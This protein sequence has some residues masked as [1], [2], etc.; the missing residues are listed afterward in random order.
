MS[1]MPRRGFAVLVGVWLAVAGHDAAAEG[2]DDDLGDLSL[3]EL[4]AV[5]ITTASNLDEKLDDA[6]ASVIVL[7]RAELEERGYRQL[8]DIFDDIPGMDVVRPWGDNWVLV[9]WR[10]F[11]GD[12]SAPFLLMVDGLPVNSLYFLDVD[13]PLTALPLT[14]IDRV[15]VVQGPASSV[16]G[17]NAFMGVVNV[18]TVSDAERDGVTHEVRLGIGSDQSRLADATVLYKHG[19]WRLRVSARFE[20]GLLDDAHNDLYEFTRDA[21]YEGALGHD[22]WGGFIDNPSFAGFR[23]RHTARAAEAHLYH[24]D[25]ELAVRWMSFSSGYG[26]EYAGDRVLNNAV[27]TR[28]ELDAY[29]RHTAPL[30]RTL[31]SR[32]VLRY[33]QGGIPA[34]SFFVDGYRDPL[35]GRVAA[36]SYWHAQNASW[37]GYQDFALAPVGGWSLITGIK[38]EQKDLQKAYD[39]TGEG[40]AGTPGGYQPVATIDATTYPYPAPPTPVRQRQN[41]ILTEDVGAYIQVRRELSANHHLHLGGRIDRNSGYDL[42]PT[43]RAGYV[44]RISKPL[45]IKALYGE[46]FQEPPPRVLY[47]GWTG[48]G[49]D[50]DL[51]PQR[52]QTLE[53]D[54]TLTLPTLW[55]GV[56][57]YAVHSADTISV[58]AIPRNSG[59]QLVI[60][61]DYSFRG[62]VPVKGV[63]RLE[64]WGSYTRL[65]HAEE[66]LTATDGTRE[67]V[68][69][70]DLSRDK[71]HLGASLRYDRHLSAT[72]RGRWYGRRTTTPTN[73]IREVD[74]YAT[75]DATIGY[76]DVAG[77]GLGVSA[78]MLNL[79]DA[80]YTHPGINDASAGDNPY[81]ADGSFRGSLGFFTSEMPQPGRTFLISLWLEP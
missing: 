13:V 71:V 24:D 16:Y 12:V 60:G 47:G 76:R 2:D 81:D 27:W 17:P 58:G 45:V 53:L 62:H 32:T 19:P 63:D 66:E 35:E 54:T 48:S 18:I 11:R 50:P 64:L 6:P 77:T 33:R 43:L 40:P 72:M 9:Y 74:A 14:S 52:S 5:S 57:A 37:A 46:A 49:S 42:A 59:E 1:G 3:E 25:T 26:V 31:E 8:G 20:T 55:Q 80:R 36:F 44:G 75:L 4:M 22:L 39:I 51:R 79:G 10:G 41:R 61:L 67:V 15:E 56:A 28:D 78:T 34:E 73:P 30:T 69:I 23:S 70:G 29:L 65:F 38:L 7:T 21:Y 68:R